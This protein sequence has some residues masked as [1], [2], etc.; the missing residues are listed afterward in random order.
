MTET[1]L[2]LA[3]GFTIW[4][5]VGLVFWSGFVAGGWRFVILP[6]R[7][8]GVRTGQDRRRFPRLGSVDRRRSAA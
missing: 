6:R 3:A 1:A 2:R 7:L 8:A 5:I 4:L